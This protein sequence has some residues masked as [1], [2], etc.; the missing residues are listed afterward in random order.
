MFRPTP[1]P[2]FEYLERR[3]HCSVSGAAATVPGYPPDEPV[4]APGIDVTDWPDVVVSSDGTIDR[5]LVAF[6]GTLAIDDYSASIDWGDGATSDGM[7]VA[8][9]DGSI[10]INGAHTYASKRDNTI[11]VH[12]FEK[13]ALADDLDMQALPF[14]DP[15]TLLQGPVR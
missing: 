6:T 10:A 9:S 7:L 13:G 1:F 14:A 11:T 8:Q 12:I 4:Y 15:L 2:R 5:T 3:L